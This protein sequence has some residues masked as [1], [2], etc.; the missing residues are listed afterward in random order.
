MLRAD[1][2][3]GPKSSGQ[4][5]SGALHSLPRPRQQLFTYCCAGARRGTRRW[6]AVCLRTAPPQVP[7]RASGAG[8]VSGA[9]VALLALPQAPACQAGGALCWRGERQR[10]VRRFGR[11]TPYAPRLLRRCWAAGARC[12]RRLERPTCATVAQCHAAALCHCHS[13]SWVRQPCPH[14]TPEREGGQTPFSPLEVFPQPLFSPA[15]TSY[16]SCQ[17]NLQPSLLESGY[18][19]GGFCPPT[20][21]SGLWGSQSPTP[22]PGKGLRTDP[23]NLAVQPRPAHRWAPQS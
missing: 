20:P 22:P 9:K 2:D 16:D 8:A 1:S 19:V 21:R 5:H 18:S 15:R 10:M 14:L 3:A 7:A 17:V 23:P 11:W 12:H 6:R 4:A 13:A